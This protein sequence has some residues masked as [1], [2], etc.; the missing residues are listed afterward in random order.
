MQLESWIA[1]CSIALLATATPGPA[2]LLVSVNSLSVG[3]R[4]SLAT[5]LGNVSGLFI[6]SG[7]SVLGLSAIVL[8]SA[9]AFIVIKTMGA[10]Y[11]IYMGLQ[12]WKNGVGKIE[13]RR[14]KDKEH[15][16]LNLYVQ[17]VLVA[18]T[19]PK[20]IIFTTALFPQ[21]V[22]VTEPL[23]PQF[24]LLVTSFMVLSFL[25]LSSYAL[26]AHR[27]KTGTKKIVS[28]KGMGKI[29]GSAFIGAGCLLATASK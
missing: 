28:G 26:L 16:I 21:F 13:T 27:A 19:N 7:L 23:L 2:A 5:V 4:K 17:G 15:G 18:L 14:S 10:A 25:C 9:L 1:F 22:S 6:M 29:V 8:N 12:L 3:F 20:A 11:L 24:S